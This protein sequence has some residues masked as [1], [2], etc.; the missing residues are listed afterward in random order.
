M[1][2]VFLSK[3]VRGWGGGTGNDEEKSGTRESERELS[4]RTTLLRAA[5]AL[6]DFPLIA[7]SWYLNPGPL[8]FGGQPRPHNPPSA[9][10]SCLTPPW[11]RAED[12]KIRAV[13]SQR[14]SFILPAGMLPVTRA[15][16]MGNIAGPR[17]KQ[18]LPPF[19]FSLTNRSSPFFPISFLLFCISFPT[20]LLSRPHLLRPLPSPVHSAS[21][22]VCDISFWAH[23][24]G[25]IYYR[26]PRHNPEAEPPATQRHSTHS[27]AH[28]NAQAHTR[29]WACVRLCAHSEAFQ[30]VLCE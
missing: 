8:G 21:P 24:P 10:S 15:Y 16:I 12:R 25:H 23:S 26:Q 3:D 5:V 29:V 19:L 20:P 7:F 1:Q 28:T 9:P 18:T 4:H 13:P 22:P 11:P 2:C 14:D 17:R 27:Q 6:P 30:F